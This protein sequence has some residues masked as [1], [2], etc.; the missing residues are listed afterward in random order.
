MAKTER[1]VMRGKRFAILQQVAQEYPVD[2]PDDG[3][4]GSYIM[5]H[6]RR[7]AFVRALRVSHVYEHYC[8]PYCLH[9]W[10]K[11]YEKRRARYQARALLRA[12]CY[13]LLDH[14]Y[15]RV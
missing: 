14:R 3:M 1:D 4:N 12:E 8:S 15:K 10:A 2:L 6:E 13:D 7:V 9:H 5:N 11:R